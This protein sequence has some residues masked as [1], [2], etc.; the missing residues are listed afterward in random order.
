MLMAELHL[1][2]GFAG[3]LTIQILAVALPL[4]YV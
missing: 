1:I 2:G 3:A 4:A